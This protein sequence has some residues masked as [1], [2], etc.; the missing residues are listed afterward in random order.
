MKVRRPAALDR[1]LVHDVNPDGIGEGEILIGVSAKHAS[2]A[3]V[4]GRRDGE[5]L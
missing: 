3:G 4:L 1:E 5:Q 2:P